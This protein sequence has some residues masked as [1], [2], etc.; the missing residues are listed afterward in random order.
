MLFIVLFLVV[1]KGF[2]NLSKY[3]DVPIQTGIWKEKEM[4]Q[5][6]LKKSIIATIVSLVVIAVMVFVYVNTRPQPADKA[7]TEGASGSKAITVQVV[8]PEE[9]TK[10]YVIKT[11]ADFLHQ[12]LDQEK[13]I[14]GKDSEYGF[15]I[16][17][18]NGRLAD[19]S[20][21]EWWCITKGGEDVFTGVDETPVLDGD[22]F[23]ITLKVGY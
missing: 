13:L 23:E 15:F 22:Q 6:N 5:K 16:T 7:D 19:D 21:Q 4:E 10:E 18:V 12:A 8:V 20:K 9:E 1:G 17:S 14:E 11:D 2:F 3:F